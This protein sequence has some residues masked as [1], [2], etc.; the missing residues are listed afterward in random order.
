MNKYK[1]MFMNNENIVQAQQNSAEEQGGNAMTDA[2]KSKYYS[3]E[4]KIT[5][6]NMKRHE[7]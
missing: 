6:R 4:F 2:C 3:Q 1:R 5:S 7:T